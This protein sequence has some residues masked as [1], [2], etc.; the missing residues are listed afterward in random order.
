M[1]ITPL[2]PHS[3]ATDATAGAHVRARHPRCAR[4]RAE[5][6]SRGWR[7]R[8][9]RPRR[10]AGSDR[11]FGRCKRPGS[12]CWRRSWRSGPRT[13]WGRRPWTSSR[14]A[15]GTCFRGCGLLGHHTRCCLADQHPTKRLTRR[16]SQAFPAQ[17]P[18]GGSW[19][20]RANDHPTAEIKRPMT[21]VI[22]IG[23]R[24]CPEVILPAASE[25]VTP[26]TF[27]PAAHDPANYHA[28]W[29]TDSPT[30]ERTATETEKAAFRRPTKPAV[31][32][33]TFVWRGELTHYLRHGLALLG[34]AQSLLDLIC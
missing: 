6:P 26:P 7:I 32:E 18:N 13:Y 30:K 15:R 31:I 10:T 29:P 17:H 19:Q 5:P 2:V 3:E 28:S 34:Q 8:R 25:S 12:G 33:S 21:D 4:T 22:C 23:A 16:P 27:V 11:P 20:R 1:G 9:A 14:F 24:P